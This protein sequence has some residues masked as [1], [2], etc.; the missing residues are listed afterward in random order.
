[1]KQFKRV[2]AKWI[3]VLCRAIFALILLVNTCICVS[4]SVMAE[5]IGFELS[6]EIYHFSENKSTYNFNESEPVSE[7]DMDS[8]GRL[9]AVGTIA[10]TYNNDGITSYQ[11][12]NGNVS[13]AYTFIL[14]KDIEE[15]EWHLIKDK[16]K[17]VN[18]ID[19]KEEIGKG[20][21]I[22]QTSKDGSN[23][24]T[25]M[26][27]SNYFDSDELSGTAFYTTKDIQLS[28]GT[29][30]RI[31]VAY[32]KERVTGY[33]SL[34]GIKTTKQIEYKKTAEVYTFYLQNKD[35]IPADNTRQ[36]M[37]TDMTSKVNT[38]EKDNGY[39]GLTEI[40]KDDPHFG[41][42]LGEFY[43]SGFTQK[44][45]DKMNDPVFLKNVGDQV[46]LYFSLKQDINKLNGND[47][48][49]VTEDEDGWDQNFEVTRRNFGRGTLIIK[50][51]NYENKKT[52]PIVYTNF[53]EA[54]AIT[55]ADT[56][57]Y[58]FEE[59]DYEVCLDYEVRY[60]KT[61]I[62]QTSL[63]PETNHYRIYF[64]FLVRNSNCMVF[65]F[66]IETNNEMN[67][68]SFTEKGFFIDMANSRYLRTFVKRE[69]LNEKEDAFI[70]DVRFN[71]EVK[72]GDKFTDEGIYTITVNNEYTG[73]TV[74]KKIYVG[75][76][77]IVK[78]YMISGMDLK[79]LKELI[80]GGATI[81]DDGTI[82]MPEPKTDEPSVTPEVNPE[83][84]THDIPQREQK[85]R[86]PVIIGGLSAAA[87]LAAAL[88]I[89]A[90]NRK[91]QKALLEK[92]RKELQNLEKEESQYEETD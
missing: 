26:H 44:T 28:N 17:K 62:W 89:T 64:K 39:S 76:N 21:L 33:N 49:Y 7:D 91:K 1:M 29:F 48:I 73:Q 74:T 86:A 68:S 85:S 66:E 77:N 24:I 15:N 9:T 45:E 59:G 5:D 20:V 88:L 56:A 41:W 10:D 37:L 58:V 18:G 72:D 47:A 11:I 27:Q 50:Y 6:G 92:K 42:E 51:T 36:Y 23:W 82:T 13:F 54:N 87:V 40:T 57:V 81:N 83:V 52:D 67:N 22:V 65:P 53:L 2:K 14:P 34:F 84:E 35:S 69:V 60:D 31:I 12:I 79:T 32:E 25:D 38:G 78:G 16:Q 8:L 30:F 61:K 80:D 75:N 63:F 4:D 70:E 19:L 3:C 43:V 71:R 46:A 55:T 90:S